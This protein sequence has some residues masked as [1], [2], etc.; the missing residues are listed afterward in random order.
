M[1]TDRNST[2]ISAW[3]DP[4]L[5]CGGLGVSLVAHVVEVDE[6]VLVLLE[7]VIVDDADLDVALRLPRL[8]DQRPGREREV[9]PGVRRPVLGPVV[10]VRR[11]RRDVAALQR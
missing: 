2:V 9:G 6:E 10:H 8:E 3:T 1:T 4:R 5:T 11:R 7:H